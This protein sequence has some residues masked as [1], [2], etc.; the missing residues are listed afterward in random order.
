MGHVLQKHPS[1]YIDDGVTQTA[2]FRTEAEP[3]IWSAFDGTDW[4]TPDVS[5]APDSA[6]FERSALDQVVASYPN[7][8]S[9]KRGES[10]ATAEDP[11]FGPAQGLVTSERALLMTAGPERRYTFD[12]IPDSL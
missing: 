1:G 10:V 4:T 5:W 8:F 7:G 11:R 3:Y 9:W 6:H 2:I 12:C